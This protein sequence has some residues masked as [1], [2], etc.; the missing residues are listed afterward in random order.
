MGIKLGEITEETW[1]TVAADIDGVPQPDKVNQL[2]ITRRVYF[3]WQA[4]AQTFLREQ[5][6]EG[7]APADGW[8]GIGSAAVSYFGPTDAP[9]NCWSVQVQKI[10][11]NDL[12]YCTDGGAMPGHPYHGTP[13]P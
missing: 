2:T 8:G 12:C 3:A 7:F 13:R 4:E 11:S 9:G 1:R 10:T 5:A 6:A